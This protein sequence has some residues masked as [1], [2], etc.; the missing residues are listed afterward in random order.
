MVPVAG[1]QGASIQ[2][3]G[4]V[5]DGDAKG[6]NVNVCGGGG[7]FTSLLSNTQ[8][9]AGFLALGGFGL[10][11]GPGLEDVGFGTGRVGWPFPG[12]ADGGSIGGGVSGS[13]VGNTWQFESGEGGFVGGDCF[14]WPGLAI[15]TPGNGLK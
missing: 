15:S 8:G 11:L 7:S 10:G 3:G 5:V 2:F 13:G 9:P 12:M 6:N 1:S 14:P 4:V